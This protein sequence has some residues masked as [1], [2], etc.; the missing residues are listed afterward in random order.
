MAMYLSIIIPQTVQ[1]MHKEK[2]DHKLPWSLHPVWAL[3]NSDEDCWKL[4]G[5]IKNVKILLIITIKQ[6]NVSVNASKSIKILLEVIEE[7]KIIIKI[8]KFKNNPDTPK[9]IHIELKARTELII[10]NLSQ[11]L[12]QIAK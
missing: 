1:M 6:N 8:Y 10:I 7:H 4:K 3:N 5:S 2:N 12:F 11:L 9:Q